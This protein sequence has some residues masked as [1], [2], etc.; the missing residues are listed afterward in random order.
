[1]EN[2]PVGMEKLGIEKEGKLADGMLSDG[3]A[4]GLSQW[5]IRIEDRGLTCRDGDAWWGERWN[6]K[7]A[8]AQAED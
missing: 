7:A 3:K 4:R 1:V 8:D 5:R 2:L 6:R